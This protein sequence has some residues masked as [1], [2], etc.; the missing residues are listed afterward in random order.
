[1]VTKPLSAS[2]RASLEEM[3]TRYQQSVEGASEF[4]RARGIDPDSSARF[5]LGL[6][7][8]PL[9]G[10][11]IYE[12]RLCVPSLAFDGHPVHAS[13]RRLDAEKEQK[14]LHLPGESRIFNTRAIHETGEVLAIAEGQLD[15]II[16]GMV[17]LHAIGV[18]GASAWKP[19]HARMV[20]GIPSVVVFG[21]G[22]KAGDDFSRKVIGTVEQARRIMMPKGMDVNDVFLAEGAD[23]IWKLVND[24]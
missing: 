20:A 23:G 10:H 2:S 3:T 14:Y 4:L 1:M 11:E 21:D 18:L 24:E 13:F 22:D 12:G 17:G 5:R 9:P 16:L 15:A 8:D 7:A 6:V 19:H